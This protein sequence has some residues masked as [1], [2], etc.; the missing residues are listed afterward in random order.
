MKTTINGMELE[1]TP[2]ELK[3]FIDLY[4]EAKTSKKEVPLK[5][6]IRTIV[7]PGWIGSR[8]GR[9][10]LNNWTR[11]WQPVCTVSVINWQRVSYKSKTACARMLGV[12]K[13]QIDK[14][15]DSWK[16]VNWYFISSKIH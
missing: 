9:N 14:N 10:P 16:A 15:V 3:E 5:E 13:Y 1:W 6:P 2:K 12:D 8:G 7:P 4:K 11:K